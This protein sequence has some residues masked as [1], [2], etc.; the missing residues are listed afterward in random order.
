MR[1]DQLILGLSLLLAGVSVRPAE[2]EEHYEFFYAFG[3][4]C[5]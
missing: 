2:A 5:G 1:S 4:A 3:T